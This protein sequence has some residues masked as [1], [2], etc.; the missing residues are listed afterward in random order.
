M[1]A[2]DPLWKHIHSCDQ[3]SHGERHMCREGERLLEVAVSGTAE[4]MA[5][6]PRERGKA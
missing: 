5:P 2:F 1:S 3:C 6:V 4:A